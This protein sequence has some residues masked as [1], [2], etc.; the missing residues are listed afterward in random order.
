MI[1]VGA[2]SYRDTGDNCFEVTCNSWITG[3]TSLVIIPMKYKEN[4]LLWWGG[5]MDL[6]QAVPTLSEID[7]E[8]I[9]TGILPGEDTEEFDDY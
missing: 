3:Y 5:Q 4:F 1:N 8:L 7:Y 9:L 2:V 6:D